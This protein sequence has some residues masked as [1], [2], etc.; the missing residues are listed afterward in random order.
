MPIGMRAVTVDINEMTGVAGYLVP[1]CHVDVIQ[2]VR[3]DKS[4]LPVARTLTQNVKVTAVG[5]RHNPQDGDG[6][7]HS[8]TLLVTPT[9]A[10]LMELACSVGRPRFALRGG[11]DLALV[12]TKGLTLAELI[13]HHSARNDE[14]N[15]VAPLVTQFPSTQPSATA[16]SASSTRPSVDVDN[17]QWTIEIIRG[18][19]ESEAK[20]SL[21]KDGSQVSDTNVDPMR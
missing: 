1:G 3:D 15:V 16:S 2:T 19:S 13:G 14:F 9:Q 12:D 10:E 8:V 11:N 18:G 5:Q 6:G 4:G 17:D 7:G 21:P 20:F